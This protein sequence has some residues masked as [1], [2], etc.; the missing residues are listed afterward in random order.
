MQLNQ[1]KFAEFLGLA[2]CTIVNIERYKSI[3]ETSDEILYRIYYFSLKIQTLDKYDSYTKYI[4]EYICQV[5]DNY[6]L[7]KLN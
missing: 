1:T 7:K 6:L 4:S 2:R 5:V 3:E